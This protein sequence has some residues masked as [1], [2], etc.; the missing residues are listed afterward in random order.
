M[1]V[2]AVRCG[3]LPFYPQFNKPNPQVVQDALSCRR[4][5]EKRSSD[6]SVRS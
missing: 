2:N 5:D 4:H 6:L 3:W 1:Q